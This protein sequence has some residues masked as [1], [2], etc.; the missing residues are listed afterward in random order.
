MTHSLYKFMYTKHENNP[1]W[2]KKT[3]KRLERAT[4]FNLISQLVLVYNVRLQV[5]YIV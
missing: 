2:L 3:K 1:Q 5:H 4:Y